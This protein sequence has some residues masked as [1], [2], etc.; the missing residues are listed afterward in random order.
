M[1]NRKLFLI[2]CLYFLCSNLSH[3]QLHFGVKKINVWT[4]IA[5]ASPS[6]ELK[7]YYSD[8]EPMK[9]YLGA[10]LPVAFLNYGKTTTTG[11]SV[12]ALLDHET[13]NFENSNTYEA[14]TAKIVSY[15]VRVRPFANMAVYCPKGEV[16]AGN[17]VIVTHH[18]DYGK[19]SYGMPSIK[20]Y[21]TTETY[22]KYT[23]EGAKAIATLFLSSIYFDFGASTISFVEPLN[24]NVNRSASMFSYGIAPTIAIGRKMTFYVDLSVRNYK[25]TNNMNTTSGIKSIHTGFGLGFNL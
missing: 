21:D 20:E 18:K 15:G 4:E 3:A 12:S 6:K 22:T 5:L 7:N 23:K 14:L 8:G 17:V 25:W 19:D 13:G 1:K 2:V 11:L 9:L 16:V 10:D 24:P